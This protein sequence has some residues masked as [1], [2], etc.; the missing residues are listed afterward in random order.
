MPTTEQWADYLRARQAFVT[1][2]KVLANA[3]FNLGDP[4]YPAMRDQYEALQRAMSRA[5]HRQY[6]IGN[7]LV[8]IMKKP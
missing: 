4:S 5:V 6:S 7:L 3:H 8:H 1:A 2:W